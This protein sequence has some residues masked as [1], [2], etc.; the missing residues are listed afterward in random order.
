[1]EIGTQATALQQGAAVRG[2]RAWT[3]TETAGGLRLGSVLFDHVWLPGEPAAAACRR[4][5]DPF[6]AKVGPHEV[7]SSDCRCGFYAA[8]DPVD[9]LSYLHGRNEP[10]TVCRILGEVALWGR[11]LEGG[12]GWRATLAYPV[13]LYVPDA[14]LAE[15]LDAYGVAISSATCESPSSRTCTATR[16]HS[17]LLSQISKPSR[18][19]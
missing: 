4:D 11:V 7:G 6:A 17:E 12:A 3:V 13:H 2:W 1:M 5:E 9:A 10:A 8:C 14:A 19:T 18:R 15:A 16:S